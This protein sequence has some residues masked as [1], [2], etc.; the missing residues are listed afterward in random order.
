LKKW[1]NF[2]VKATRTKKR[3]ID[4]LKSDVRSNESSMQFHDCILKTLHLEPIRCA[5]KNH[6][7][8]TGTNTIHFC[9]KR[10][11]HTSLYHITAASNATAKTASSDKSIDFIN[12]QN[13]GS[14]STSS[15]KQR[16]DYRLCFT[17]VA[18]EYF[19]GAAKLHQKGNIK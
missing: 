5:N 11:K 8:V 9:E 12:E 18:A 2:D 19:C 15:R 14:A 17:N 16:S 3:S 4:A 6:P 13:T 1:T 7:S 10:S